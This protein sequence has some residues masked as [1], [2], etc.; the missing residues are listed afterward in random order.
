[1]VR[2]GNAA[3]PSPKFSESTVRTKQMRQSRVLYIYTNTSVLRVT[4]RSGIAA[5][6][7]AYR[8]VLHTGVKLPSLARLAECEQEGTSRKKLMGSHESAKTKNL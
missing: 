4:R 1:M 7:L 6:R 5:F 2:S 8:T 3:L